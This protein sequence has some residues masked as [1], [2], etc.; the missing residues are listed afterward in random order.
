MGQEDPCVC[1]PLYMKDKPPS[2]VNVVTLSLDLSAWKGRIH[3]LRRESWLLTGVYKCGTGLARPS[4]KRYLARTNDVCVPSYSFI[5]VVRI[6]TCTNCN[7]CRWFIHLCVY[8]QPVHI[9]NILNASGVTQKLPNS[10]AQTVTPSTC[11]LDVS[12]SIVVRN[13][14]LP[15]SVF[16][17]FF[18]S[19][20][21]DILA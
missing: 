7:Y 6:T 8:F 16:L 18:L 15:R 3:R 17:C 4:N 19:L 10:F 11:L 1:W 20:S 13:T 9:V 5:C 2:G 14:E 12:S 21:W